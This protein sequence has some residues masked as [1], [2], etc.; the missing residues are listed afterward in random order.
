MVK[1]KNIFRSDRLY[2]LAIGLQFS[3]DQEKEFKKILENYVI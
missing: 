1:I 2:C 3:G